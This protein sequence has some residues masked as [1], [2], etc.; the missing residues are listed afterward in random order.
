[1]WKDEDAEEG[2]VSAG[3]VSLFG[4]EDS[5]TPKQKSAKEK[6]NRAQKRQRQKDKTTKKEPRARQKDE[7]RKTRFFYTFRIQSYLN[8]CISMGT[9]LAFP[10]M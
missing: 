7:V 1:M 9:V 6:K 2:G 3:V 8:G 5:V 4:P 10:F